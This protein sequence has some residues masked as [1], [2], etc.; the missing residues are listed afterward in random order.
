MQAD[1]V[2]DSVKNYIVVGNWSSLPADKRSLIT[3]T[4]QAGQGLLLPEQSN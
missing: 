3:V 4:P 2:P 1:Q